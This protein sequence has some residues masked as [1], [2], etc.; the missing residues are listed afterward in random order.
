M[1]DTIWVHATAPV[2][3]N[4]LCFSCHEIPPNGYASKSLPKE[5]KQKQTNPQ[6]IHEMPIDRSGIC[7]AHA[8][9]LAFN[10]RSLLARAK[11]QI[12]QSYQTAKNVHAVHAGKKI[13]ERA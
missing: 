3:H 11:E 4:C 6:P 2:I 10:R 13:E 1:A 9:Q 7:C 5:Q 8:P 12:S